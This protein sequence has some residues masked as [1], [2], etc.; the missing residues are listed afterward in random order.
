MF[1]SP[2]HPR[3]SPS[4]EIVTS[5]SVQAPQ[6]PFEVASAHNAPEHTRTYTF[7]LPAGPA[8]APADVRRAV[9][10]ARELFVLELP[11]SSHRRLIDERWKLTLLRRGAQ[12][13]VEVTY[14]AGLGSR[15][16]DPPHAH[17]EPPFLEI[18]DS[19]VW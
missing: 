14:T 7:D 6:S 19:R 1:S 15:D 9:Q 10:R 11:Q 13:R 18:I 8:A 2:L 3:R 4:W 5:Q 12:N 16:S 17:A